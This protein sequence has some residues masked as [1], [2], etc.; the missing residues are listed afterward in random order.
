MCSD[1]CRKKQAVEAKRDRLEQMYEAAYYHWY[2]RLRKLKCGKTADLEKVAVVGEAFKIFR[3]E[4]VKRK[5]MVK[6]H[7]MEPADF[8][9][10]LAEQQDIVDQLMGEG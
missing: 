6:Q 8:Y 9:A 2:N 1:D 5:G 10:W 7:E 3:K 4:A